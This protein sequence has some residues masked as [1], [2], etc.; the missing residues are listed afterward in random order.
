MRKYY[1][2]V[3]IG[4]SLLSFWEFTKGFLIIRDQ[5]TIKSLNKEGNN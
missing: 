4:L 5:L 2:L 3:F 1:F